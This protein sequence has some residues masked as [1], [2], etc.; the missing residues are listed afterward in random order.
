MANPRRPEQLAAF[1]AALPAAQGL[2]GSSYQL[3]P[4]LLELAPH[5]RVVSSISVGVDNYPLGYLHG[6]GIALCHTPGALTDTTADTLF[7]LMLTTSRRLVELVQLVRSGQWTSNIG[8]SLYGHARDAPSHG[9]ARHRQSAVRA[10]RP[11]A[12]GLRRQ[13]LK[14]RVPPGPRPRGPFAQKIRMSHSTAPLT[15]DDVVQ[16]AAVIPVIVLDEPRHAVPMARALVAGGIR[17]LEV[18]LRTPAALACIEAIARDVPAAVVGAG[19]ARSAADVQAAARAG[20]RFIVSPGYLPALGQACRDAGLPLLPG[21]ATASEIMAAGADGLR[22]LKFFPAMAAGGVPLLKSWHG[23]FGDVR[24]CPTGGVSADNA[25]QLLAL[26]NVACVGG[27]WLTPP[28]L[29]AEGDWAGIEA[30]ARQAAALR[31]D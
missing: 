20:A 16:D 12:R 15:A 22:V 18:T 27:S 13:R 26:P 23:P 30:L 8:P 25:A 6:R 19:T 14:S 5:L 28:K 17:M 29:L 7:A 2:I 31:A 24:F 4:E 9:R 1:E 3:T 11:A 21:V 10:G